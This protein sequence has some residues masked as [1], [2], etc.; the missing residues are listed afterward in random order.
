MEGNSRNHF[1]LRATLVDYMRSH[2]ADFEPFFD[3]E[4][5]D[6]DGNT[7]PT[8]DAYCAPIFKYLVRVFWILHEMI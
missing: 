8:F 7:Q 1:R 6:E 3:P 5:Q 2:R 4:L